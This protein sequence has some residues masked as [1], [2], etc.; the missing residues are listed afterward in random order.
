MVH[1]PVDLPVGYEFWFDEVSLTCTM[2][3][4]AYKLYYLVKLLHY[5]LLLQLKPTESSDADP[6]NLSKYIII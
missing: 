6:Y 4:Y 3:Y 2:Y 5:F 1:K